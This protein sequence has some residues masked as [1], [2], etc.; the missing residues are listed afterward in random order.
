MSNLYGTNY[1][2]MR[3]SNKTIG[4][5]IGLAAV[6]LIGLSVLQ[7][8][9]LDS[10]L[11]A[12]RGI[13]MQKVDIIS[14][15]LGNRFQE[16]DVFPELLNHAIKG[17][18]HGGRQIIEVDQKIRAVIDELLVT[19]NLGVP[20]EYTIYTHKS[21]TD[22]SLFTY[23]MG[24]KVFGAEEFNLQCDQL[25]ERNYGWTNLTCSKGYGE[26]DNYHLALFFPNLDNY[27]FAQSSKALLFSLIFILLLLCSISY[28]VI[29]IRRQKKLSTIKN[30]FINNLTHEFKTPLASVL[31]ASGILNK[32]YDQIDE[33][34]RKNYLNLISH[35][36]KRLEGQVDK[37]LQIA[38][39]DSGNFTLEKKLLNVHDVI[40]RVLESMMILVGER[41]GKIKLNLEASNP[42]VMAD[43]THLVNIIS[44][45]VDNAL[46]YTRL[47]PDIEIT[48]SDREDG[49]QITIR[50]NGIGIGKEIQKYVFDKFYRAQGGDVHNVKG[51]G[52][53]LS[54]VKKIIEAHKGRIDLNSSINHGTE[55]RLFFP[56]T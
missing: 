55:F 48:T 6:S 25:K 9:Y 34:K 24:N 30:D 44:N 11:K 19:Y 12:N 51:F 23:A 17:Q 32:E 54:Y 18:L 33:E 7:I 2:L 27:L 49:V 37:I 39:I 50:D 45:L 22:E 4:I 40:N 5:V 31:L 38:M 35:E 47:N 26:S 53:G 29:V 56:L 8:N 20:Y 41:N 36:S 52:L 43:E 42:L 3:L 10:S 13:F 16:I 21:D 15:S 46:K 1:S 28:M 14:A